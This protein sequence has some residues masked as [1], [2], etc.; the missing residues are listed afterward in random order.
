M[1]HPRSV[2]SC[3]AISACGVGS[4]LVAML[5]VWQIVVIM[6]VLQ[7]LLQSGVAFLVF[8]DIFFC[9]AVYSRKLGSI[10]LIA[11]DFM[12]N[13]VPNTANLGI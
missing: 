5:A 11:V 3:I 2:F 8:L 10:V 7:I 1:A 12:D 4:V 9:S 6:L 13:T